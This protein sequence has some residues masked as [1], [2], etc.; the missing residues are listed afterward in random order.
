MQGN[1]Y[2]H[3]ILRGGEEPNYEAEH[4]SQAVSVLEKSKVKT[5]VMVD[6][7]HSNSRKLFSN[8]A[9]VSRDVVCVVVLMLLSY[10]YAVVEGVHGSNCSATSVLTFVP[11]RS[12]LCAER[13]GSRGQQPYHGGHDRK[14]SEGMHIAMSTLHD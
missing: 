12:P 8:Q 6:C 3:L 13:A 4:V 10:I 5:S 1:D 9:L 7:S 14:Q 2:C 11:N